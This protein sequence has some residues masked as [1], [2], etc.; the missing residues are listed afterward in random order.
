MPTTLL[1]PPIEQGS[2][3][4][5]YV[6]VVVVVVVVVHISLFTDDSSN[7]ESDNDQNVKQ[8]MTD[9]D[10]MSPVRTLRGVIGHSKTRTES[11]VS[12]SPLVTRKG[13]SGSCRVGRALDGEA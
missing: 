2:F 5:A 8:I 7:S 11:A 9:I 6:F 10:G 13:Y 4:E 1:H 12:E 3:W